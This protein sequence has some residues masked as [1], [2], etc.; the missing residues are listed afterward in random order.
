MKKSHENTTTATA[1][2]NATENNNNIMEGTTMETEMLVVNK[3]DVASVALVDELK[4]PMGQLF[5]SVQD[6]GTR[7]IGRASC[8]ERV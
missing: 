1:T 7:K 6:D 3:E 4:N 8:R 5:S 2:A